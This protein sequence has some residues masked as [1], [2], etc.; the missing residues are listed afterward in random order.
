MRLV[1]HDTDLDGKGGPNLTSL[2]DMLFLLIIFFIVS[3]AFVEEEKV[4]EVELSKARFAE[5]LITPSTPV[6]INITRDG[7]VFLGPEKMPLETLSQRL[8]AMNEDT[9]GRQIQIRGDRQV[10]YQHVVDVHSIVN[11]AG[12]RRVDYKCLSAGE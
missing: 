9:K 7:A 8:R 11:E 3:S 2:I 12:F 10:A 4:L 6:V 5:A 1:G